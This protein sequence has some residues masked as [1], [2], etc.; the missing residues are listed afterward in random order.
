[1]NKNTQSEDILVKDNEG[2]KQTKLGWIPKDWVYTSIRDFINQLNGFAFKSDEFNQQGKGTR[3]CRGINITRGNLRFGEKN[4]MFWENSNNLNLD[5]YLLQNGDIV[6]SM[7]GSLVGR[8]YS[9]V[10]EAFLPLLLVQRV[11]RLRT[12]STMSQSFLFHWISSNNFIRY[13]DSVKTS[14][15]IPHISAKDINNFTIAI[16]PLPEQQKIARILNTWD[17]AIAAQEKLI[18]EKHELKNGLMQ[19]LLTGKKRFPEF[20]EKWQTSKLGDIF[21]IQGRVGWKGYKKEDL[22]D[23]GPLVIGAKHI[24]NQLLN[25]S[26]PTHLSL[27]K[28]EESPEIM[29]KIN[30]LL[31]V[32]RGSLG[33]IA[34]IEND[35][36]KATIN[37]S[38]AILRPKRDDISVKYIY[39][40]LC[41]D[42]SQKL[43]MSETGSTGVPMISQKQISTFKMTYPSLKEQ[44][45]I[46]GLMQTMDEE[47]SSLKEALKA[48]KKQKQGL[49]QQLLTGEKRVNTH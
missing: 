14:S 38:M 2:Y 48:L 41:S 45:K 21:T 29:I 34:V 4:E 25:L 6:I 22:R 35:L 23:E 46:V 10:D 18:T 44:H 37:P 32:Q 26:D 43:I 30:D 42:F 19:Q 5:K 33:K 15:G 3:L 12:K 47:F 24:K 9:L 20:K 28:Y 36:G 31:I 1:M 49:M 7:D 11:A 27:E 39:Y 40:F 17:K 16:P 13:V 8:N